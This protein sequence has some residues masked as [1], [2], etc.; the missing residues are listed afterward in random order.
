[1]G[2]SSGTEIMDALIEIVKEQVSDVAAR[3]T[4]YSHMITAFQN[5][6]WDNEEECLGKDKAYDIAF[7]EFYPD[8]IH[9]FYEDDEEDEE[10]NE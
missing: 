5:S 9:N 3:T 8:Y 10:E 7:Y 1:M 4:I 6:D 2:W